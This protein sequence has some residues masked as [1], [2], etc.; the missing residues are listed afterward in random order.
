MDSTVSQVRVSK[1]KEKESNFS[2]LIERKCKISDVMIIEAHGVED[3]QQRLCVILQDIHD[4]SILRLNI[5][6]EDL[7]YFDIVLS[8]KGLI[9]LSLI[10][11]NHTGVISIVV[12]SD[13]IDILPE[14]LSNSLTKDLESEIIPAPKT[15]PKKAKTQGHSIADEIIELVNQE[16]GAETSIK[17]SRFGRKS[18]I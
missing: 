10:L 9:D 3:I 7:A 4:K 13:A 8:S 12:P 18:K 14:M 16:H 11:R 6:L 1:K 5:T 17:V 15:T 2:A